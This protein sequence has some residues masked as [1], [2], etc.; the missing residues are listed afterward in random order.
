[1]KILA[2][3]RGNEILREIEHIK[4]QMVAIDKAMKHNQPPITIHLEYGDDF[5]TP[6]SMKLDK[7]IF[8]PIR[9]VYQNEL[10]ELQKELEEL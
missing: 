6:K 3:N 9:E 10:D 5:V 2:L 1:M 4:K 8:I 7:V